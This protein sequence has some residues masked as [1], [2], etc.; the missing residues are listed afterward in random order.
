MRLR[1]RFTFWFVLVTLVPIA[2]AALITREVVARNEL[3]KFQR[4]KAAVEQQIRRELTRLEERVVEVVDGLD[5]KHPL[6]GAL[7]VDIEKN[8]GTVSAQMERSLDE[9]AAPLMTSL[10][11]SV[12]FIVDSTDTVL[13]SPHHRASRGEI[14][15]RL[16]KRAQKLDGKPFYAFET[17]MQGKKPAPLLVVESTKAV[18]RGSRRV[19]VS[20]AYELGADLIESVRRPGRIDSQI[21]RDDEAKTPIATPAGE[22]DRVSGAPL[23]RIALPGPDGSTLAWVEVAISDADLR[24]LQREITILALAL[25]GAAL[26]ITVLLGWLV[27]RRMTADLDRLVEGANAAARGDLEHRVEVKARDEIGELAG[28]FNT[29]M[30]DLDS[31]KERL[32]IAER[33][34]AWQEIARRLAHEIKNPLTPIQMSVETMRKTWKKQHPSFEEIFD[35]STATVLEETARLKRIV[36]EFSEFARLPKPEVAPVDINDLV[37]SSLSLYEGSV[38]IDKV[39][40]P[41]LPEIE[42][43]RDQL[44]QVLLNLF[45]NARDALA[46][47]IEGPEGGAIRV[48]TTMGATRD[49][50]Q[51]II[52]D[53]GPGIADELLDKLFTPYFTTKHGKGGTGLG[54]AI[55]HRIVSDHGGRIYAGASPAGGARFVVELPLRQNGGLYTS[56]SVG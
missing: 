2:V 31:S 25:A 19:T 44:S 23:I 40:A 15:T 52:D 10:G 16:A 36:S 49:R 30:D 42:G 7:L 37:Q 45:E 33:I 26:V 28:A 48:E 9:G 3:K 17:T 20:A 24:R 29:M 1:G 35:E 56:R 41:D 51:L 6:V 54:L 47:R 13:A 50:V 18:R 5:D 43:D 34:A 53:N 4:E 22:W 55:V 12:L 21:V 11:V 8:G 39:L 14:D 32:V 46:H 27:A 38:E